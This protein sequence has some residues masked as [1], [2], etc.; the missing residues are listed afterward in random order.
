MSGQRTSSAVRAALAF[1]AV[2][3]A[4]FV[5]GFF[6]YVAL[7]LV[8]VGFEQLPDLAMTLAYLL[9]PAVYGVVLT[10]RVFGRLA[11]LSARLAH[12]AVVAAP[13]TR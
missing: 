13:A 10:A 3:W 1:L 6:Y 4:V 8:A 11:T 12:P 7:T 2:P 5:A 9:P